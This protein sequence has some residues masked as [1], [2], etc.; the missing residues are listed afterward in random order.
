MMLVEV[1]MDR[2]IELNQR[3]PEYTDGDYTSEDHCNWYQYS[4]L[5]VSI[6]PEDDHIAALRQHMTDNQF[7]PNAWFLSDHGSLHLLTLGGNE[8]D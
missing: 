2:E 5:V 6:A 1:N 3:E 7:W 8:G 4:K